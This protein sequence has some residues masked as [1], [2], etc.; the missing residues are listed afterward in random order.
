MNH[1]SN[2]DNDSEMLEEYDFSSGV[3]GKYI[4]RFAQGAN[5]VVLDPDVARVFPDSESVN[6]VLRALAGIIQQQTEKAN[7]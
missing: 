4:D 7:P 3:R 1:Q 5:V 2:S 6:S